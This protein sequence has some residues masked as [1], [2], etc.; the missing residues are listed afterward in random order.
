MSF[1]S[2]VFDAKAA[3]DAAPTNADLRKVLIVIAD[4][5]TRFANN[6]KEKIFH[7]S[8]WANPISYFK[9]FWS[10]T[11]ALV[12]QEWGQVETALAVFRTYIDS[13]PKDSSEPDTATAKTHAIQCM[14]AVETIYRSQ[15]DTSGQFDKA[16]ANLG[17][18]I[19]NAPNVI[20]KAMKSAGDIA[21]NRIVAPLAEGL[22]SMTWKILV[23]ILK[24]FWWLIL[25]IVLAVGGYALLV[26]FG[27]LSALAAKAV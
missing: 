22:S 26:H 14:A 10:P 4:A 23:S 15:T 6:L 27:G 17:S 12:I 11:N 18:D 16:L 7:G 21:A 1:S 20:S 13:V 9:E 2:A 24:G 5:A 8:D 3:I 19:A 25:I